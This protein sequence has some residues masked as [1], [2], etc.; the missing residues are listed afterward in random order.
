MTRNV[1]LTPG[2]SPHPG[3]ELP[4]VGVGEVSLAGRSSPLNSL[5][6]QRKNGGVAYFRTRSARRRLYETSEQAN[7]RASARAR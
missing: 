1:A 2:L 7:K 5:A 3:L 6:G 4:G